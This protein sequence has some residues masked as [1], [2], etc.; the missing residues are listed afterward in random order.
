MYVSLPT[1]SSN[2]PFLPLLLHLIRSILL[3]VSVSFQDLL[4]IRKELHQLTPPRLQFSATFLPFTFDIQQKDSSLIYFTLNHL[5]LHIHWAYH[6]S[7]HL[8]LYLSTCFAHFISKA[9]RLALNTNHFPHCLHLHLQS[10][11]SQPR[12]PSP[13]LLLIPPNIVGSPLPIPQQQS[14]LYRSQ[15][16]RPLP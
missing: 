9:T 5:L 16:L 6:Y 14:R 8:C 7:L 1:P 13:T 15:S 3:E 2:D 11:L 4:L 12:S 10:C